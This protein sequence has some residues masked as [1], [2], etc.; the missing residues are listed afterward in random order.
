MV[1]IAFVWVLGLRFGQGWVSRWA[2]RWASR[3]DGSAMGVGRGAQVLTGPSTDHGKVEH[4]LWASCL[5]I[6]G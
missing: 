1:C 3:E 2:S 5:G 6:D 4:R